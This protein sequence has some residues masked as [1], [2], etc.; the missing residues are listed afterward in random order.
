MDMAGNVWEWVADWY[1][2]YPSEP[3]T[4]PTG[5]TD[6]GGKV[7]R[8]GSFNYVTAYVRASYRNYGAPTVRGSNI[9][10]RCVGVAPGQ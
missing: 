8:G 5:S 4:N 3:Q 2:E 1:D 6:G 10:F 9:G 7:L